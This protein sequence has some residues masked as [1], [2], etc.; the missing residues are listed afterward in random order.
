MFRQYTDA[1]RAFQD[2]VDRR[3]ASGNRERLL[4]ER[5]D[6]LEQHVQELYLACNHLQ[7][8]ITAVDER[9]A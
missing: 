6:E 3:T 1:D 4:L 9:T 5:I 7:E 2:S 8:Y